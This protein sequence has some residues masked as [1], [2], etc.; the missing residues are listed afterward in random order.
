MTRRTRPL[1]VSAVSIPH[2]LNAESGGLVLL[3]TGDWPASLRQGESALTTLYWQARTVTLT[4]HTVTLQMR[5]TEG[6]VRVLASGSPVHG[7][8]PTSQWEA[9]EFVADR[10]ILRV[11]LDALPGAYTLE[12]A[13]DDRPAQPLARFNVQAVARS[14]TAPAIS[15][16]MSVTFGAQVAL[17]GYDVKSQTPALRAGASV[18][19][20]KSQTMM[21]TLYW[22]ALGEMDTDYTVFVHLVDRN[23]TVR[24]QHDSMPMNGAYP[25]TLWQPGEFVTDTHTLGLP[26]DLPPGDYV[27]EV[28]LYQVETGARL[29]VPVNGDEVTLD[30]I[31]VTP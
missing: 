22:Q 27:L 25:T 13:V 17:V 4:N 23:G 10:L 7:T 9:D 8:Y 19:N 31:S 30:K 2:R 6:Q 14:W 21:L 26:S 28:G 18:S 15:H 3:G 1:D 11:P 20:L 29:A 12:V 16:P 5:G 24:G